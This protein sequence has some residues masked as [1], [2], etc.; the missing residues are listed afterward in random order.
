MPLLLMTV[1]KFNEPYITDKE[2]EYI[3]DVFS[4][5]RFYGAGKY[6][7]LCEKKIASIIGAKNV[8]LTD[9][10]TA[11][12]EIVALL[13]RDFTKKQEIIVPSVPQ[14]TTKSQLFIPWIVGTICYSH[15]IIDC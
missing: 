13:L 8:S 5:K 2:L 4:E 3:S 9:S 12:L 14:C 10:C 11:A 6:T 1:L 7:N 15:T